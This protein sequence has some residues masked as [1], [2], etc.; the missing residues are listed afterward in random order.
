MFALQLRQFLL[1]SS[2]GPVIDFFAESSEDSLSVRLD[3][4]PKPSPLFN[5]VDH[6]VAVHLGN[7]RVNFNRAVVAQ[8]ILLVNEVLSAMSDKNDQPN[9]AIN[10]GQK[11][12]ESIEEEPEQELPANNNNAINLSLL[13]D[14]NNS[15]AK[16]RVVM[17]SAEVNLMKDKSL[18]LMASV[19]NAGVDVDVKQVGDIK[20]TVRNISLLS[21]V[22]RSANILIFRATS[23][24]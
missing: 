15:L 7:L 8:T 23:A 9:P 3:S 12:L 6:R 19:Q 21:L 1:D 22:S 2:A 5:G 13:D 10:A 4:N 14:V 20:I 11:A 16:V 24:S 17:K 18:F